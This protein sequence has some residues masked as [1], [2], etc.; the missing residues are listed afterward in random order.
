MNSLLYVVGAEMRP[1]E[2]RTKRPSGLHPRASSP[3]ELHV[4]RCGSPPSAG[5]TYT[6]PTPALLE[7]NATHLPS[8][9][10]C[11]SLSI[12][13]VLVNRRASPPS[14]ET[15]QRSAPYSKAICDALI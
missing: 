5:I 6:A 4:M 13:G 3:A 7:V 10:K 9:E 15:T 2:K 8:G 1:E 14:R 12:A 11:G